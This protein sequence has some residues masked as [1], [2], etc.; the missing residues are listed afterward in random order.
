MVG[1]AKT[2]DTAAARLGGWRWLGIV[3]CV[4]FTDQEVV[5]VVVVGRAVAGVGVWWCCSCCLSL[6][7]RVLHPIH[8]PANKVILGAK[9]PL[10]STWKHSRTGQQVLIQG[11]HG[12]F[13]DL[14][15]KELSDSSTK[16]RFASVV[17]CRL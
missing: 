10:T 13:V 4:S 14:A 12:L 7:C 3:S 16:F 8:R 1:G 9:P 17:G 11:Q 5:V 2:E 6:V 15:N